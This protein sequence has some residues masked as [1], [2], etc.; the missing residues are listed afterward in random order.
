MTIIIP[1]PRLHGQKRI[2]ALKEFAKGIQGIQT[3]IGYKYSARGWCYLMEEYGITKTQFDYTEG[4]INDCRKLGILPVDFTAEE[5]ARQFSGVEEPEE[6][7]PAERLVG[8]L[9]YALE[10]GNQYTPDWW[11]DEEYYIQMV[12]E[13]I[14]MK[15]LFE[16]VCK[17]YHIPIATAK[18][19]SSI[20]MRA[21]YARRFMD[22]QERGLKSVLLYAGDHDPDGL[23]ISEFLRSNLDDVKDIVWGDG[24]EGYDPHDLIIDR[25][26]LNYDFITAN[27]LTWIDNLETSGGVIAYK[28]PD[29]KIRQGRT[30]NGKPHKNFNMSYVQEYLRKYGV[31]K[32]EANAISKIPKAAQELCRQAIQKYLG[33]NAINRFDKLRQDVLDEFARLREETGLEEA[34]IECKRKI[35][36]IE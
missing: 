14:D 13:K 17:L 34:I 18:G 4:L 32:C 19:W 21:N 36:E 35:G 5:E 33:K 20:T 25:F 30:K 23:R 6:R 8:V 7:T 27:N 29:G 24:T 3:Q 1:P 9:N 10:C 11:E 12:V 28:T 22:A 16:P 31:R 2:D 15:T 26:G